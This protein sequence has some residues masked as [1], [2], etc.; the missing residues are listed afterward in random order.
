MDLTGKTAIL[1]CDNG[2]RSYQTCQELSA[3]G[4][5]CRFMVGGLEKW[6]A[7][8]RPLAAAKATS[9]ADFRA[10]PSY[11]NKAVLLDTPDVRGLVAHGAV[12]VDVRYPGEFAAYH[13]PGAIDLPIRPTKSDELH[14]RI[15]A[16]P[17][18]PIIAP[19]Y[20]RRSCFYAQVLGFEVTQAG[21]DFR[22]RYT[23]PWDYFVPLA[24]RPYILKYLNESHRNVVGKAGRC[25]RTFRKPDRRLRLLL[26]GYYFA[27]R[28][29]AS[30]GVAFFVE[31]R[32]RSDRRQGTCSPC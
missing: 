5:D 32:A 26:A 3:L 31:I 30:V 19:C 7:E 1:F 25:C 13:L 14:A 18:R 29:I 20:D 8:R 9:L 4:I 21:Y 17:H 22:G 23:V 15:A 24:P 10:L 2:N 12:F 27:C 11:P 28:F 16:L 6:L